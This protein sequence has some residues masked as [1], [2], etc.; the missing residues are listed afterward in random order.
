MS[1]ENWE[2][3]SKEAVTLQRF[4]EQLL[5]DDRKTGI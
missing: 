4:L 5:G 3:G 2:S 1:L